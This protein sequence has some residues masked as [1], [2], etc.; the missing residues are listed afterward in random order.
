MTESAWNLADDVEP[1][2]RPEANRALV[3][4]HDQVVLHCPV[5]ARD[6]LHLRVLTHS[7]GDAFASRMFADDVAAVADVR[8]WT[9]EVRPQCV[10]AEESPGR[11]VDRDEYLLRLRGPVLFSLL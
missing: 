10:G 1:H 4:G 6:R 9:V 7:R 3:R 11:V 2:V 8:A 5:P